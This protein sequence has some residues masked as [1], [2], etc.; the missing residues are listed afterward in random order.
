[1]K[2]PSNLI[3]LWMRQIKSE[4]LGEVYGMLQTI[5]EQ[6]GKLPNTPEKEEFVRL[7]EMKFLAAET[8]MLEG[9]NQ[10]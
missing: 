9:I 4:H 8:V 6:S 3:P 2:L 1:M 7:V 5:L 10:R